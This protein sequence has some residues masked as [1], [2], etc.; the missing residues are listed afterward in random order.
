MVDR[1]QQE[2]SIT[3]CLVSPFPP[4]YG[5]MAIQAVKLREV[6]ESQGCRVLVVPTNAPFPAAL[7][8]VARIPLLRTVLNSGLFFCRLRR[9][10]RQAEVVY[11][12]TGFFN[13]FWWIS[14][15]ALT[16]LL[17]S[18][19]KVILSARGGGAGAFFDRYRLLLAPL[20]RRVDLITTPS[21][22]LQKEFIRAFNLRPR[23]VPNIAD[24]D[25]FGFRSQRYF[26]PRL[27]TTRN[28]EQIYGIDTV[29]RAF[30]LVRR[31]CPDAILG[32]VGEGSLRADLEKLTEQLGV[33][34]HVTFYGK[35]D[36]DRIQQIYAQYDIY[37]NASRT[38]NL[39][40]SLLE[41]FASG[42]PVVS[43]RSGGIAHMIEDQ[44]TGLLVDV[45]DPQALADGVLKIIACPALG[46]SLAEAAH[47][48][49][50][51]Y[52][53]EAVAPQLMGLLREYAHP[54]TVA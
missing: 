28:L 33:A 36:H 22:F 12:L 34:D 15:P 18:G 24:L 52:A 48:D 20:M 26:A 16:L 41:A 32:L 45:D 46:Q 40:G 14:F 4:P 17:L 21:A 8:W 38:D 54:E 6:L 10:S 25:Q 23:V 53:R 9:T 3:V 2:L 11:F 5:G 7:Q 1:T 35:V 51:K 30:A 31:A 42:L 44:V 39:P 50:Q 43:T 13:F 29:L 37:I 47:A 27:L 49:A 19:K